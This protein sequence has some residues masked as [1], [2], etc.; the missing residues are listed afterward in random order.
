MG[1]LMDEFD[2]AHTPWSIEGIGSGEHCGLYL[3]LGPF[4][5]AGVIA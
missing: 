5:F 1:K 3:G 4:D 2:K